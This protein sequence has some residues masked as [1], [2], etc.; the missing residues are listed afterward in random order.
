MNKYVKN[1][2]HLTPLDIK[3]KSQIHQEVRTLFSRNNF[4]EKDIQE[5]DNKLS[6]I[7]NT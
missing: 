2:Y 7:K 1:P 3:L 6:E 4:E 5:I